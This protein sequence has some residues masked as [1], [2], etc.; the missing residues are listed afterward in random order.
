VREESEKT[1]EMVKDDVQVGKLLLAEPF[2]MDP[3]FKRAVVLLCEHGEEGTI[4]FIMNKPLNMQVDQ[5]VQDFPEDF[6][7]EVYFG[8]PVQTDTIHFIHQLGDLIEDSR[9]IGGGL[10]WGGDF[11]KLK[12][13][14][15]S[16]LVKPRD[17]RFFVGY[18]GWSEGQLADEMGY[19]SWVL[20][21]M[22]SNYLFNSSPNELW[23]QVMY[24]KGDT[25]TIL[26]KLPASYCWN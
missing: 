21:D 5:L 24:D 14:M 20:A 7:A 15:R 11:D 2:M 10:Y 13:L 16:E 18:A 1:K 19:G 12:F 6:E 3:N 22:D 26:S 25:F 8:G 23:E 4:G 17:I 9:D